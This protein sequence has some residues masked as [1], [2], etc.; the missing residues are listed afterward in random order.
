MTKKRIRA[1]KALHHHNPHHRH[2]HHP[3]TLSSRRVGAGIS[4]AR[5]LEWRRAR[6][7]PPPPPALGGRKEG[8]SRSLSL[9]GKW[10]L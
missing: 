3:R 4:S 2:R 8:A 1:P 5:A 7:P 9:R 6:E 10:E